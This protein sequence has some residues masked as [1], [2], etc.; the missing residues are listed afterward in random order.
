MKKIYPSILATLLLLFAM[1]GL[2]AAPMPTADFDFG[3]IGP[4]FYSDSE[5][6]PDTDPNVLWFGF[7]LG[8]TSI[9]NLNTQNSG[10]DTILSLYDNSG[11]LLGQNDQC[12][13][14]GDTSCLSFPSLSAGMYLAGVTDWVGNDAPFQNL[15]ELTVNSG[16]GDGQVN[17]NIEVSAVPVP[18]AVWLFGSAL[19][20]FVGIARRTS[21]KS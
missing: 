16:V 19:I 18:A 5:F 4:G 7:T 3:V 10:V 12:P 1:Q 20:G 2:R 11:T 8:A 21:I 6:L 17:L 9:V 13:P 14:F 15:W